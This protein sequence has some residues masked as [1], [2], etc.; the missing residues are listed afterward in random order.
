MTSL[1]A[2]VSSRIEDTGCLAGRGSLR[3]H[4]CELKMTGAPKD[5]VVVDFDK[6]GSPLPAGDTP[7][8]DYLLVAE[9]ADRSAWVVVLEMKRGQLPSDHAASQLQAGA[10]AAGKLVPED[11][12]FNFLPIV[13]SGCVHKLQWNQ[14]RKRANRVTLHGR[15]EPV[16]RVACGSSL[17]TALKRR[18]PASP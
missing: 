13:A 9:D 1:P 17:A 14:Q 8:C 18:G 3:K 15:C 2:R 5:R 6:P 7:R 10:S 16:R 12:E 4:G 11:S